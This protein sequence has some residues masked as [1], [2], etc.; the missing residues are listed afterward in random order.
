MTTSQSVSP[1]ALASGVAKSSLRKIIT[2]SSVGTLI[3]WYDFYIY[4]SLA[5]VFSGMFFPEGNGTAALLVTIAAFGTGFV[6]RP[7]GAMVFGRMGDRVGRKK[8]F[9][10]TLLIMG[11]ATTT[12][13]LMPTYDHIGILAPILLVTLR[14]LQGLAIGGEYGGA[15]VYIAENSP[16]RKRGALTS[17]LQTTATGG[18][19]LSIGVIVLCRVGLG[20]EAFSVWGWRIPFL[21]SAV[22]VLFSLKIRMKMHESPVFEEMRRSG[23]LSRSPIKDAVAHKPAFALL[24]VVL[25]G[26]TAGLGVAWYT[27]QFYTLYFLQTILKIDF[28]TANVSVGIALVIATP[29]FVVFGKMSDRYGRTRIILCGLVLSAVGYLP[30]FQWVRDAAVEDHHIQMIVPLTIQVIFVTMV[31]GP[32]AAFLSELFPPQIRYTGLSLAYHIGTGVFGG[33]TPL[34]ALSLNS[35]TGNVLAGLIYPIAVTTVTAVVFVLTL[36]RGV[37]SPIVRR[38]WKQIDSE[39]SS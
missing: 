36:R 5:V 30:L 2:A 38:A 32:T 17:V 6:V 37:D 20:E 21:L 33:F 9:M 27:S 11:G 39:Y 4:G 24:L 19:L 15:V 13:G 3:E 22:L 10:T 28:L 35:A 1:P 7:I 14:L 23:N 18:L 31:Y 8:T 25:F 12:L 34:V 16:A 29:F 26:I